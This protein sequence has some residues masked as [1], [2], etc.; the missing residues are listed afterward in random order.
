MKTLPINPAFISGRDLQGSIQTIHAAEKE[1]WMQSL[2][3]GQIIKGRILRQYSESRYGVSFA[4]Q[5]RIVDSAIPL[6][7]GDVL[8][9]KVVGLDDRSISVRLMPG[10]T[11]QE[12]VESLSKPLSG[13]EHNLQQEMDRAGLSL[14]PAQQR[15]VINASQSYADTGLA[16]RVSIFLTKLGLPLSNGVIDAMMK[17]ML[18][19]KESNSERRDPAMPELS[20]VAPLDN[21]DDAALVPQAIAHLSEFFARQ[22]IS[23]QEAEDSKQ[24]LAEQNPAAVT[25]INRQEYQEDSS[26]PSPQHILHILNMQTDASIQHRFQ[27][28]PIMIEGRLREFDLALFDQ[29]KRGGHGD[30]L[31]SRHL[32]FSLDTDF[33]PVSLDAHIVN[34]RVSL[35]VSAKSSEMKAMLDAHVSVLSGSLSVAGWTLDHVMHVEGDEFVSPAQEVMG[36]ILAQDSLR[37]VV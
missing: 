14:T 8:T 33:G 12:P 21:V 10:K 11:L 37:M 27:T 5:E 29:G 17:K 30:E 22:F 24:Q 18:E 23:E 31:K 35:Q 26:S 9:G 25:A 3:A 34:Q 19:V 28:L 2:T 7:V 16:V 13:A 36:H 6:T 4:G 15:S 20:F 1:Q 32:K